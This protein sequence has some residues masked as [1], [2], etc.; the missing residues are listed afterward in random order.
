MAQKLSSQKPKPEQPKVAIIVLNWNG[1][2]NTV[3]CLESIY[4]NN[5]LNFEVI[6]VDNGSKDD[7]IQR[8]REYASGKLTTQSKFFKYNQNGK[9]LKLVHP[10]KEK[11]SLHFSRQLLLL[12][13]NINHGFALGTNIGIRLAQKQHADYILLLNNDIVVDKDFL[14]ELV[15]VAEA[16]PK[17]GVL[18]PTI[19]YYSRPDVVDF[20]GENLTLWQ[21]RGKEYTST[22]KMAREV[23]KIEGS[24]ILIRRVVIDQIGLLYTKY[25]AYWEETDLCFRAKKAGFKVTY[26]PQSKIWHKVAQSIGGEGNLKREYFLN[27]NRLLF[28]RRNLSLGNQAKFLLYFF[29]FEL[30]LKTAVELKHHSK[31]GAF[32]WLKAAVDGLKLYLDPKNAP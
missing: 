10:K 11:V 9:P 16:N 8:I 7:S 17:I 13:N 5:Y 1:W 28:A 23:D 22:S 14:A 4:Q 2:K 20:A 6:L 19:Y 31:A 27:R 15:Y 32:M 25:W 30:W 21:V 3:E 18:G 12:D 29:G 24:C 26:V